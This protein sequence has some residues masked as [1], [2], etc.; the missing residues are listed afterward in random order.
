MK[1]PK[2]FTDR[3]KN[4]PADIVH[5][6]QNYDF[7][8]HTHK[9]SELIDDVGIGGGTGEGGA[10]ADGKSA[11]EV[12]LS[13]GNTGSEQDFIDSLKG[14]N[15]KD[16]ING[17]N[18]LDGKDGADGL[19]GKDGIDGK[20]G[21]SAYETWLDLG[22]TGSEQDFIDSLKGKDGSDGKNG[23]DGKDGADGLNGKDGANGNNGVNGKDGLNGLDGK[24]GK[25]AYEVWLCNVCGDFKR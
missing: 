4:T 22:N 13:L 2:I 10:G 21:K 11:Y 14:A 19:S 18:G 8:H 1:Y 12:W 25:S 5:A 6:E 20:D 3:T 15:G 23:I 9:I 7:M 17:S 24:D 16:G